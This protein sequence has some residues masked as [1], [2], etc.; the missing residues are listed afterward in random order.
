MKGTGL[1]LP[2]APLPGTAVASVAVAVAVAVSV[3]S[4]AD[5]S[6]GAAVDS[7]E[8]AVDSTDTLVDSADALVESA[9][10]LVDSAAVLVDSAC[11]LVDWGTSELA[12]GAPPSEPLLEAPMV[13]EH[14]ETLSTAGFPFAS[15]IGVSVM[16]QTSSM[17]PAELFIIVKSVIRGE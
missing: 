5:E 9:I 2:E 7:D 4:V 3:T 16:V 1:T 17:V 11:A 12:D 8:A 15:V 14:S 13:K 6:V 10:V